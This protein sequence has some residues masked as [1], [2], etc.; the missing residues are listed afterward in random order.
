MRVYEDEQEEENVPGSL[1]RIESDEE[2]TLDD[3][4][5]IAVSGTH[6][7]VDGERVAVQS[8]SEVQ[9]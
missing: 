9:H 1:K 2:G 5:H 8:V 3:G 7:L 6:Y 4:A